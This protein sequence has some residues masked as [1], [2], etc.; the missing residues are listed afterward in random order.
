MEITVRNNLDRAIWYLDAEIGGWNL[1]WGLQKFEK[2]SWVEKDVHKPIDGECVI[3]VRERVLIEELI[4]ELKANLERSD[5]WT[6]ENCE[7]ISPIGPEIELKPLAPGAYRLF[8]KY[9]FSRD[10]WE[11]A[12]VYSNEFIVKGD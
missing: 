12:T 2:D 7:E 3:V 10:S 6:L 1:W 11:E 8:F 4:K 5:S 9:G